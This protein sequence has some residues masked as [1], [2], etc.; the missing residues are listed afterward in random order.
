MGRKKSST[1]L[2]SSHARPAMMHKP[3]FQNVAFRNLVWQKLRWLVKEI[4]CIRKTRSN[5]RKVTNER[6][7]LFPKIKKIY[8]LM[9]LWFLF[10]Y[11]FFFSSLPGKIMRKAGFGSWLSLIVCVFRLLHKIPIAVFAGHLVNVQK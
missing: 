2:I 9:I 1:W 7:C 11:L 6:K 4:P 5:R 10:I 3:N 8:H